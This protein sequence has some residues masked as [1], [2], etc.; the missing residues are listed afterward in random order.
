MSWWFSTEELACRMGGEDRA[1][2][3]VVMGFATDSRAVV[4]GDLFLAIRGERVD[5]HAYVA[6]AMAN[7]A[8]AALVETP[9]EGPHLLVDSVVA[10]LARFGRSLR[11]EFSGPVVGL[12]GSAGKTT[13]KEMLAAALSPLG[14]VVKTE[15]N[16]NT[17]YTSPLLW[18]E[19]G[20]ET[21]AVV[22]EMGMR[23]FG[24][25]AHLASVARPTVGLI[26]NVGWSHLLQVG[27]RAGIA[28]AKGELLQALPEDGTCVL[29]AEDDYLE[30]LRSYAGGRRVVTF[31]VS[32]GTD[33]RLV[34]YRAG[35]FDRAFARFLVFGEEASLSLPGAGRHLAANA[36]AAILTARVLDVPLAGIEGAITQAK[37]P[38][39]RMETRE[40]NGATILLDAYNAAPNS[41]LAAIE[42]L[43]ETPVG[44]RRLAILGE[45][46]ELGTA[47]E[48]AHRA[49]GAA[50]TRLDDVIFVGEKADLMREAAGKGSVGGLDD[51][52][53]FLRRL[54]PGDVAL[55]KGS[56]SLGLEQTLD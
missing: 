41:V 25:I 6:Q 38:P 47:S 9:V 37:L 20:T 16:R 31:G 54:E 2:G 51:A 55:V 3:E 14:P 22:V 49:V 43:L 50:T 52:R 29:W 42:T 48:E 4:P 36:A 10:G 26:T 44:G 24:Q 53:A 23:G 1:L 15:G 19:V 8:A 40:R 35:G 56:R 17:E 12:T 5:G 13:T 7:G 27:D 11:H 32:E 21:R 33:C 30:D 28:R 39:M 46:K 34:E 18:A 45:M